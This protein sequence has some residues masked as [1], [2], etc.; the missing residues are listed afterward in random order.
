MDYYDPTSIVDN[1]GALVERYRFS[2]F[3]LRSIMTPDFSIRTTSDYAWDFA[4]KGQFLDLDTGYYN[5]GYRYY[6]P[7]IGRWL[8]RDP[9]NE[10]GGLNL[11]AMSANDPLNQ[12]DY[13]GF[14]FQPPELVGLLTASQLEVSMFYCGNFRTV[15]QW[16]VTRSVTKGVILQMVIQKGEITPCPKS[17]QRSYDPIDFQWT[18]YWRNLNGQILDSNGIDRFEG[19]EFPCSSGYITYTTDAAYMPV[20]GQIA[21]PPAQVPQASGLPSQWGF[22]NLDGCSISNIFSRM[23]TLSWNCCSGRRKTMWKKGA[24]M[25]RVIS[26]LFTVFYLSGCAEKNDSI[27]PVSKEGARARYVIENAMRLNR[28]VPVLAGR[29]QEILV[30]F[31]MFPTNFPLE[32]DGQDHRVF[33]RFKKIPQVTL[34]LI[35]SKEYTRQDVLNA[36]TSRFAEAVVVKS[37]KVVAF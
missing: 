15:I 28:L 30:E 9:I 29:R 35:I 24:K 1:S 16:G 10:N 33:V 3:G 2:A 7:Q 21:L 19:S 6:S 18:E 27:F 34:F 5:Y 23:I 36:L 11:Y 14:Y 13:L 32:G 26:F 4:F 8:S 37:F 12:L 31:V 17:S 20:V 22:V 25:K